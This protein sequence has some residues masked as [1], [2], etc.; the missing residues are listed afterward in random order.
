MKRVKT[1][2]P[3]YISRKEEFILINYFFDS[4][5]FDLL[6]TNSLKKKNYLSLNFFFDFLTKRLLTFSFL[7]FRSR[8]PFHFISIKLRIFSFGVFFLNLLNFIIAGN[9]TFSSSLI[10][11]LLISRK[12]LCCV[13][14]SR[15]KISG[16]RI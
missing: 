4:S 16:D 12:P 10:R 6:L 5:W 13:K 2:H 1:I 8:T 11:L 3:L 14:N 9:L 15:T 7:F